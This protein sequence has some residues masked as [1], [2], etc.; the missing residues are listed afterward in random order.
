VLNFRSMHNVQRLLLVDPEFRFYLGE[1]YPGLRLRSFIISLL[2]GDDDLPWLIDQATKYLNELGIDSPERDGA[3]LAF[4]SLIAFNVGRIHAWHRANAASFESE[5]YLISSKEYD[6][7]LFVSDWW[8][9]IV[10]WVK[11][12]YGANLP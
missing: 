9:D 5:G 6:E 1:R 3:S 2:E 4:D 12:V 8:A 7:Y 11:D 10:Q